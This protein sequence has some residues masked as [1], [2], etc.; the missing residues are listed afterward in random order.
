M[1]PG[2]LRL[3]EL[4][5][6][7]FAGDP[8]ERAE[9]ERTALARAVAVAIVNYRAKHHLSQRALAKQLGKPQSVIGRL[10]LGEHNPTLD[11]LGWL[12]EALGTQFIV[13]VRPPK[14]KNA[15]SLSKRATVLQD[16][17]LAGGGQ[18]VIATA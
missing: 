15:A 7:E 18:L 9:W 12:S 5:E 1:T 2:E 13:T 11:T 8:V 6:R 17:V 16:M 3:E 14:Q 10:E 4:V